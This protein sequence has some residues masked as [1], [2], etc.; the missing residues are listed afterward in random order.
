MDPSKRENSLSLLN[1]NIFDT[2]RVNINRCLKAPE[3]VSINCNVSI[4]NNTIS[5]INTDFYPIALVDRQF[6]LTTLYHLQ[7]DQKLNDNLISFTILLFDMFNKQFTDNMFIYNCLYIASI[8]LDIDIHG[9]ISDLVVNINR[10]SQINRDIISKSKLDLHISTTTNILE[11]YGTNEIR[12]AAITC[13]NLLNYSS[14]CYRY[15]SEAIVLIA[16]KIASIYLDKPFKYDNKL[17][18]LVNKDVYS[19][20][21]D[22]LGS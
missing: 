18:N 19:I 11:I 12:D 4:L 5:I 15:S 6:K 22:D 13:L 9:L 2:I 1:D 3:I 16:I 14:I 8:I 17:D 21:A 20:I 7:Q 10:F